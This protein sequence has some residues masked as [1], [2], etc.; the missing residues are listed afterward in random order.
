MLGLRQLGRRPGEDFA[1]TGF[2]DIAEAA[3]ALPSLTTLSTDPRARGHQAAGMLLQ[4][5]ADPFAA[6][7][8]TVAPAQLVVR[9]SSCPPLSS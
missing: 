1:V 6:V 3:L 5:M 8:H 2:D 4:R 7:T 9:A